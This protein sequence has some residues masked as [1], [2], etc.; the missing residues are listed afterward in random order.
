MIIHADSI[1]ARPAARSRLTR[2][3]RGFKDT[4]RGYGAWLKVER[5]SG[6]LLG[7]RV[8][9]RDPRHALVVAPSLP[10]R[11]GSGVFR[12]TSWLTY[13]RAN[14]WRVTGLTRAVDEQSNEAG[15]ALA[16]T[17]PDEVD[18]LEA[19]PLD[20]APSYRLYPRIDGGLATALALYRKGAAALADDP[21][22]V[23]V[24]TGPSFNMFIAAYHLARRFRA[25]LVLDYRDEWTENPYP[26]TGGGGRWDRWWETRCLM[27][28]DAVFFTTESQ[29]RH[30]ARAFPEYLKGRGTVLPN[31]WDP[32][33]IEDAKPLP[34]SNNTFEIA[35][36]GWLGTHTLPGA[37]LLDCA[38]VLEQRPLLAETL[39]L[40]F[41]GRRHQDADSEISSF[42][43]P[44]LLF[45]DGVQPKA[46][47]DATIRRSDA[48]LLMLKPHMARY[49]SAKIFEYMA[50]G[51][52]ILAHG[53]SGEMAGL[54][55]SHG[56]GVHVPEGDVQALI[57]ALDTFASIPMERWDTPAR[58]QWAAVHTR[59]RLAERFY[60]LLRRV[61]D[62]GSI[63][64]T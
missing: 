43:R 49:M 35:F 57:G 27:V 19:P 51:R 46:T 15:C 23:V 33:M 28:A 38:A 41:I 64:R 3:A 12:P 59:A 2:F 58:R 30:A 9:T 17:V 26:A 31:G 34:R 44:D 5:D 1:D 45:L 25:R 7:R 54:V 48:L 10:P 18:I 37:F 40:R 39:R 6:R 55:T 13:A 63:T 14:G 8:P 11:F 50:S 56:A 21:P 52:P 47:A 62:A 29:R 32:S 36:S 42:P 4:A 24:G 20:I 22:A 53:C 16:A 60:G 61:V